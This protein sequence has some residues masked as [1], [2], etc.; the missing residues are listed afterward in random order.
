MFFQKKKPRIS[1]DPERQ[2]PAIRQ[3]IC[4]GEMTAGFIDRKTGAFHDV[5]RIDGPKGLREFCK[6]IGVKAEDIKTI[7]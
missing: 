5:M 3:S 6:E 7:Y 4:T 1:F 2:E